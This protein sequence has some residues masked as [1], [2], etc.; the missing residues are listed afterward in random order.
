KDFKLF[1]NYNSISTLKL[2]FLNNLNSYRNAVKK[3][4][5]VYNSY[6]INIELIQ[7][8]TEFLFKNLYKTV[9]FR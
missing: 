9:I 1:L 6:L 3:T 4:S 2:S 8:K 7:I 5:S